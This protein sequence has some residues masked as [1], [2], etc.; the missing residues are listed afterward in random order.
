M[1]APGLPAV[2]VHSLLDHDPV[3]V[4]GH[5]ETVE[6]EI[7]PILDRR[8]VD[9]GN[10]PTRPGECRAIETDPITD[11]DKLMRRLARD[12]A[13]P[14]ANMDAELTRQGCQTALPKRNLHLGVSLRLK[15]TMSARTVRTS[16][17][18]VSSLGTGRISTRGMG[19]ERSEVFHETHDEQVASNSAAP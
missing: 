1:I 12:T 9:L 3:S 19:N 7:K 6:I 8:T 18:R 15:R 11:R 13:A 17:M 5:D 14:T 2:A 4:I 10:Q 16:A